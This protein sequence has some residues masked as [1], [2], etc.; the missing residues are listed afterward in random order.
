M[1]SA[2]QPPGEI[3]ATILD[4]QATADFVR[5]V[6]EMRRTRLENARAVAEQCIG[7]KIGG[8]AGVYDTHTYADEMAVAWQQ[9]GDRVC[10]LTSGVGAAA[11]LKRAAKGARSSGN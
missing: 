10:T 11:S 7:H 8:L 3:R 6:A 2:D 9:W 1:S 5:G 4:R